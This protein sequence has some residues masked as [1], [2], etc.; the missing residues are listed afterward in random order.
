MA[1]ALN[2]RFP[3]TFLDLGKGPTYRIPLFYT[4]LPTSSP[5]R[6]DTKLETRRLRHKSHVLDCSGETIRSFFKYP[7]LNCQRDW[8]GKRNDYKKPFKYHLNILQKMS[9][10]MSHENNYHHN[11]ISSYHHSPPHPPSPPPAAA[12]SPR[13]RVNI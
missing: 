1:C 3:T 5:P 10:M 11:R 13:P 8:S 7:Y 9:K 4:V 2:R 6:S 12:T